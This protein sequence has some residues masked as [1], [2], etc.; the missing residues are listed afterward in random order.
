MR[1]AMIIRPGPFDVLHPCLVIDTE[2]MIHVFARDLGVARAAWMVAIVQ[3]HDCACVRANSRNPILLAEEAAAK[4]IVIF[5]IFASSSNDSIKF[6][7][8]VQEMVLE[9]S[10][11]H[12]GRSASICASNGCILAYNAFKYVCEAEFL[13]QENGDENHIAQ[14]IFVG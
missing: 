4:A 12:P 13:G 7:F 9:R 11:Y 1:G 6:S 8:Y 2:N 5:G 14:K 3:E 10:P